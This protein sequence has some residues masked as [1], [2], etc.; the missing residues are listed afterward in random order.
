MP[1]EVD[2]QTSTLFLQFGAMPEGPGFPGEA[3]PEE[4]P[5]PK[6]L[7]MPIA[8]VRAHDEA[9]PYGM[10]SF[11]IFAALPQQV[12]QQ[13]EQGHQRAADGGCGDPDAEL[14]VHLGALG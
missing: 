1:I 4:T 8:G 14:A 9:N 11:A 2:F 13:V 7:I 12:G 3:P 5:K 10:D 6:K